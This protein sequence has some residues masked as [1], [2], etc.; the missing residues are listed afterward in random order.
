MKTEL[1]QLKTQIAVADQ[2]IADLAKELSKAAID[3]QS[4]LERDLA[5]LIDLLKQLYSYYMIRVDGD[6]LTI[7]E[8]DLL[9]KIIKH[10]TK[11]SL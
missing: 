4:F 10:T 8:N 11:L 7:A 9:N 2:T 5:T 6:T 3:Y 1:E